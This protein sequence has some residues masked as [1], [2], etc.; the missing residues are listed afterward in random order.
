MILKEAADLTD[1]ACKVMGITYSDIR[2]CELGDQFINR[3]HPLTTGKQY[4][5]DKGIKEHISIDWNG[6][7][8]A[9]NRDLSR[10]VNEWKGYFDMVTNHGTSEHV[11]SQYD[12]FRNIHNFCRKGGAIIGHIPA[13]G[14]MTGHCKFY[15]SVDFFNELCE[16]LEYKCVINENR[17]MSFRGDRSFTESQRTCVNIVLIK[18]KDNEFISKQDV[19]IVY[20]VKK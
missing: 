12:V 9:L 10:P 20:E 19:P 4:Y 5:I 6:K 3:W 16:R 1:V 2:M 8:G 15:Y 7:N 17:V 13:I 11:E 18:E 14:Y